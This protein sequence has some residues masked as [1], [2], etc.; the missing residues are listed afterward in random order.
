MSY[1][2]NAAC[3]KSSILLLFLLIWL[4]GFN[5]FNFSDV[6]DLL[7]K[8]QKAFGNNVVTLVYKDSIIYKKEIGEYFNAKTQAPI[9]GASKWLA[10]AVIMTFVD[11]GKLKLD[12][13]IT[14]YIPGYGKYAKA[15][16]TIRH[17]LSMTTGIENDQGKLAKMLT[18]KRFSTLEEEVNAL[19]AK[20]ISNNPGQEF[21][22]GPIG[23]NIAARVVEI[24][25]KKGFDR[26]ATERI[27]RPLKMRGT[28]FTDENGGATN[29]SGGARSTANDYM[30]FL[31]MILKKG[32]FDGKKIL[33]EEAI[34]EMQKIQF[35]GLPVKFKP[36][37]V[38]GFDYGLGEWIEKDDK[39]NSSV[40]SSPSLSGTWP[41]ID[42][43]RGYA[44]IVLTGG[45]VADE[46]KEIFLTLKSTI[47]EKIPA[48]CK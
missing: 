10:T 43:C 6:D 24:I 44:I 25:G 3:L 17:C 11:Q 15:Y 38:D 30:N 31:I 9:A 47:D 29:P 1:K 7:Q 46:K 41:L 21:H 33:S 12:D 20:E 26:L 22:D 23:I 34:A 42:K 16:L 19:A 48:Q 4:Q 36:K 5:Q 27:F 18:K 28:S 13:P 37:Q 8:N 39:G 45:L 40:I 2:T 32:M 35:A 14:K